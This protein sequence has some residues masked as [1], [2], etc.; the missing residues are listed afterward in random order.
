MLHICCIYAA[1]IYAASASV[2]FPISIVHMPTDSGISN[3]KRS[4]LFERRIQYNRHK[5]Y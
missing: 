4:V 2:E 3:R 5:L 1:Y